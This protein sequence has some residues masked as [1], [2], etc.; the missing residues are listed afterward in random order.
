VRGKLLCIRLD[1]WA[2]KNNIFSNSQFGFRKGRGT[3]DY[4]AI[5]TTDV[6]ISFEMKQQTVAAFI[7]ITGAY[8][9]VLIDLLCKILDEKRIPPKTI[10]FL[11]QILWKKELFFFSNGHMHMSQIIK[12]SPWISSNSSYRPCCFFRFNGALDLNIKIG[13]NAFF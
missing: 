4:L 7:D 11:Y 10:N 8:D 6:Q 13:N 2:E 9:N 1:Y 5:L 12:C 3:K